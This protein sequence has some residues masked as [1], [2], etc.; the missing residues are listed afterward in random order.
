MGALAGYATAR[1]LGR[2]LPGPASSGGGP[3][4]AAGVAVVCSRSDPIASAGPAQWA[5]GHLRE[6]CAAR[7]LAARICGRLEEAKPDELCIVGTGSATAIARELLGPTRVGALDMPESLAMVPVRHG[8]RLILVAAAPD[9]PGLVYALTELADRVHCSA[10]PAQALRSSAETVERPACRVR[11]AMR[12]FASDVE[13]KGWFHDRSFW[14][15]YLTMLVTH[16]F[17]RINLALG[18]GYDFARQLRDTYFYFPYPFFVSVP[19]YRVRAVGLDEAERDRN[20]ETL[21][22]I[23]EEAAR[24]GLHF[25]LG[26]WTH[27]FEWTDS[28]DANYTIDGLTKEGHAAYCRDALRTL[29]EACPAIK[30]LT[31]RTH[32]ESGIPEGDP[33]RYDF[34][35]TVFS[36]ASRAGRPVEIDLHAKGVDPKMIDLALATGLPVRVSPKFW[37][38]HMGL[39]YLQSSI[40]DLELPK[41]EPGRDRLMALSTGTRSHMRYSYGD[42]FVTGRRYGILHRVWPGT[43]RLLLWGDPAYAAQLGR[44]FGA[45]GRSSAARA[46]AGPAGATRT[47]TRR[48]GRRAGTG[49]NT[50]TR[51]A[52]GGGSPTLPTPIRTSGGGSSGTSSARPP[53]RSSPAW[54]SRAASCPSSPALIA[55]RPPTTTTG[56]RSTATCRSSTR[57]GRARTRT[58]RRR[59]CSTR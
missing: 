57:R 53:K 3:R 25:Q 20:M 10:D 19:G 43:Q 2:G 5:A 22:F 49:A 21:R 54:R 38:E 24:R 17:N 8:G 12:L 50:S 23:G 16:R 9:P 15:A 47:P 35:K 39:P 14:P 37:A 52:S 36:A 13:D 58:P 42:L 27:A 30:G 4:A 55:L 7:G 1:P 29:L 34:W 46:R 59:G 41:A 11:S 33:G 6:T 51:I 44:T 26:L 32:G 56:R 48:C 28:P 40:R 31:F 18:L 45:L